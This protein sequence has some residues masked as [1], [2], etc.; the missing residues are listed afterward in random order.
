MT[1][2]EMEV[3][4]ATSRIDAAGHGALARMPMGIGGAA[5]S[6]GGLMWVV[7]GGVILSGG[8]QPPMLF[9]AAPFF[10]GAGL[11]AMHA[12]LANSSSRLAKYGL[13]L[14][15]LALLLAI[16]SVISELFS[17]DLFFPADFMV[18]GSL[19]L[20]GLAFVRAEAFHYRWRRWPLA[21][22]LAF[23]PALAIGAV[24]ESIEE[25]YLEVPLVVLGLV[26]M[27]LGY[28]ILIELRRV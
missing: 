1:D 25:R 19:V 10:F 8:S 22:G 18:L 15:Y 11:I 14:A 23:V 16:G 13:A 4:D 7:K 5:A 12:S 28:L 21:L 9:E 2:M 20:L 6:V 24:L 26:W 27:F 17:A 3:D